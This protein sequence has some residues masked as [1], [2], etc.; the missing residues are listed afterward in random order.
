[1]KTVECGQIFLLACQQVRTRAK[2]LMCL[3]LRDCT[4]CGDKKSRPSSQ[5]LGQMK[6][7]LNYSRRNIGQKRN[8]DTLL[9][10]LYPYMCT[11]NY[12]IPQKQIVIVGVLDIAL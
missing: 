7:A 10:T 12:S 6:K 9:L 4:Q 11:Q 5:S 8:F 1:M 3:G 2:G